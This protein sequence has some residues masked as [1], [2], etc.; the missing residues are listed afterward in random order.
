MG[1]GQRAGVRDLVSGFRGRE[2]SR[3]RGV[4][5]VKGSKFVNSYWLC[6]ETFETDFTECNNFQLAKGITPNL[7]YE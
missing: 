6:V 5:D 1:A 3:E 4:G 2:E 7:T